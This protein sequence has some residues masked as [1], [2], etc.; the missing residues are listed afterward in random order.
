VKIA[1]FRVNGHVHYGVVGGD[2][3]QV[4]EGNPFGAIVTTKEYYA[5]AEVQ[6]LAPVLPGKVI[7]VGL[8]YS[9]HAAER[10]KDVPE[11]PMIFM[12]SPTSVVGPGEPVILPYAN[13]VEHEA[14][15]VVVI[16]REGRDIPEDRAL[17]YVLGYTCGNDVSDRDLQKKDR[18]FTRAKSFHTFKPMGPYIVTGLDPGNLAIQCRVNGELKQDATTAQLIHSVPKLISFISQ[19]MTLYPGDVI[20]T[21]TPAGVSPIHPGDLMEIVIEGIGV[22]ANPVVG[23]FR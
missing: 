3:V 6:V 19:V 7:A 1:R 9:A 17:D 22:L 5:L 23:N 15:L 11:E 8:N 20:F 16:G 18:Q 12:V 4:M 10:S 2:R 13:T 14:E 21:G